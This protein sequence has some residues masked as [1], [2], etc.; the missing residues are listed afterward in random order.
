MA[1]IEKKYHFIYKTTCMLNDRYYFGMHSTDNINDGYMGSGRRLKRSLKKY[2][3][4]NH[5]V[6]IIEFLPDRKSLFLREKEIVSLNEIAKKNCM[7]LKV[8]GDGGFSS[9]Q[10]RI[11]FFEKAS[12]YSKI[13]SLLA[14][15]RKV[16][17]RKNNPNWQ[18]DLNR[19][20]GEGV[21]KYYRDNNIVGSFYGKKH[22]EL[23][24]EKISKTN[25][26][27]LAGTGNSQYGTRWITNDIDNKKIMKNDNLPD[28]WHYGRIIKKL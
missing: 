4:E 12:E 25:K 15:K 8:G 3:K 23:S 6:E 14:V 13:N 19:K 7:N 16:E 5:I 9:E 22:S 18:L 2:G 11:K 27:V 1:R 10:H 17:I 24:K 26:I 21:R 20:T 28:G